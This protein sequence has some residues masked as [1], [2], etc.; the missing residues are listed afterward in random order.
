MPTPRRP[1]SVA[2][3]DP[4]SQLN[5]VVSEVGAIRAKILRFC[6]S[7]LGATNMR[8]RINLIS[9][10]RLATQDETHYLV[11]VQPP[12]QRAA[13]IEINLVVN[14]FDKNDDTVARLLDSAQQDLPHRG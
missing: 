2:N 10:R 14:G 4:F 6:E 9:L 8:D 12:A 7:T 3:N 1:L 5:G 13:A 11:S